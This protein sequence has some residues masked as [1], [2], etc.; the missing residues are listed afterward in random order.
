M[1]WMDDKYPMW[2]VYGDYT[3]AGRP[4]AEE[5]V[6]RYAREK[7]M[8]CLIAEYLLKDVQMDLERKCM[9]IREENKRLAPVTVRLTDMRYSRDGHRDI[10]IGEQCLHLRRVKETIE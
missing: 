3:V 2:F 9:Q 1:G 8:Y 5:A 7:Y 6:M 10:R 4:K